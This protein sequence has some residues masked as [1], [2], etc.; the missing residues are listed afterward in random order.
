MTYT[1]ESTDFLTDFQTPQLSVKIY[2]DIVSRCS[3]NSLG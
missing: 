1:V 3:Q 2:A